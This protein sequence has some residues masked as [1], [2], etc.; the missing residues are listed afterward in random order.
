[1]LKKCLSLALVV[2]LA[3]ASGGAALA[4]AGAG[5][6]GARFA[7]KVKAGVARLGA[8]P[9]ARVKVK[10]RDGTRLEGYV[11]AAAEEHFVV[12]DAKTGAGVR[13]PYAQVRS[14]KGN[15]LS[16]Q[17]KVAIGVGIAVAVIVVIAVL[18]ASLD[19]G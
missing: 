12:A 7:E 3:Q 19:D 10:L 15:N 11:G 4:R 16:T 13:V 2:L 5:E 14:V 17:A 8:G 18:N 9:E 1:M 6:K